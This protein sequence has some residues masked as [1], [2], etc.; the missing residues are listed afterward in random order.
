MHVSLLKGHARLALLVALVIAAAT[1]LLLTLSAAPGARAQAKTHHVTHHARHAAKRHA[2]RGARASDPVGGTADP[3]NVQSGDQST[4][5]K[6]SEAS[7]ENES[8]IESEQGQ[9]REPANGHQDTPGADA[10]HECTGN[11]VE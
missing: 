7:G 2:L 5:D 1:M 11:C 10:N 6:S 3:D 9:P 4:P 8:S